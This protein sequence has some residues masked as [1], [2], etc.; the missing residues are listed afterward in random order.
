MAPYAVCLCVWL[1][2]LSVTF[3]AFAR[4]AVLISVSFWSPLHG[5]LWCGWP[6]LHSCASRN[7][8]HAAVGEQRSHV[9][10]SSGTGPGTERGTDKLTVPG[11]GDGSVCG[12]PCGRHLV[13]SRRSHLLSVR[14]KFVQETGCQCHDESWSGKA[15]HVIPVP[16]D[17]NWSRGRG[18][19]MAPV[20]QFCSV[21]VKGALRAVSEKNSLPS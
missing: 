14:I 8:V 17:T 11:G 9:A 1:L 12:L 20:T 15:K 19:G 6:G 5:D 21:T 2:S 18:G 7:T 13:P 3:P 4:I 16:F 10:R